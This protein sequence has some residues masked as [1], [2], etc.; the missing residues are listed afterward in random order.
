MSTELAQARSLLAEATRAVVFT[1]AGMSAESGVPTF[2]DALT[3]MWSTH[4]PATLASPDGWAADPD[5]VWAWYADR[6]ANVREVTPNAG[7]RAVAAL[8]ERIEVQV[9]TQNVDDLHERAGS[10]VTSHLH[11]SLFAPRCADCGRRE[12]PDVA[13]AA[14]RPRCELCGGSIRPGVVWFGEMLPADAWSRAE[15]AVADADL[16]IVVGTTGVVYP[17]AELPERVAARGAPVIEVNPAESA[18]TRF[19]TVRLDGGAAQ[20]LPALIA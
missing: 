4:D 11:G 8:A 13:L 10:D 6:A 9:V 2:R 15:T 17:A 3:G 7:H 1:G 20:M 5:L 19:A 18:V 12:S 16:M 14:P